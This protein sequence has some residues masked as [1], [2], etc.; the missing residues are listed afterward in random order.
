MMIR[1]EFREKFSGEKPPTY[2]PEIIARKSLSNK[3]RRRISQKFRDQKND[4]T[5]RSSI[6]LGHTM[7]KPPPIRVMKN[8]NNQGPHDLFHERIYGKR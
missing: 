3:I 2:T 1:K 4:N 7:G 5:K 6:N 8:T